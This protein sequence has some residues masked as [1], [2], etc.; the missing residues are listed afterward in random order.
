MIVFEDTRA[1]EVTQLWEHD[2]Y[3]KLHTEILFFIVIL[4]NILYGTLDSHPKLSNVFPPQMEL[5]VN[6]NYHS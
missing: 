1:H 5:L 3:K 6:L 4:P 2:V